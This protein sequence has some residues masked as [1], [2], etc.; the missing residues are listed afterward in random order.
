MGAPPNSPDDTDLMKLQGGDAEGGKAA[1]DRRGGGEKPQREEERA[2]ECEHRHLFPWPAWVMWAD[3]R[4]GCRAQGQGALPG[5]GAGGI[6]EPKSF[7][8]R[9]LPCAP[10]AQC[11]QAWCLR[12]LGPLPRRIPLA[13]SCSLCSSQPPWALRRNPPT[14]SDNKKKENTH[15]GKAGQ[16]SGWAWPS[17]SPGLQTRPPEEGG[18]NRCSNQ[19]SGRNRIRIPS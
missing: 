19:D 9:L 16:A 14:S 2:P 11:L 4:Q 12:P 18:I 8:T 5:V 17:L 6:I 1:Q 3:P 10:G 7:Q 13:L 15:A